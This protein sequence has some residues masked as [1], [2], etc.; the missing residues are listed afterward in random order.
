MAKLLENPSLQGAKGFLEKLTMTQKLIGGGLIGAIFI[1]LMF[2]ILSSTEQP[3]AV[4][5]SELE[6]SDSGK[7][8][9]T[10]SEQEIDY[11]LREGGAKILV[12]KDKV[13]LLRIELANQGLP[14]VS[15]VGYELFDR[16]NLGMSEFVQKLNFKRAL[17]GELQN[18]IE[19]MEEVRKAR[20]HIVIPEKALFKKDQ[21]EPTASITLNLKS[22]RS[23]SRINIEGLQNL[24][25]SSVEGMSPDKVKVMD[26]KARLL[27]QEAL[28][29]NSIAGKTALQHQQQQ[30]IESH[31]SSKVQAML[32]GVLGSGNAKVSVNADL[33]F[34]Q[35]EQEK[36][37]FDPEGQVVRSEQNIKDVSENADSLSYPY[38][39]QAKDETNQIANY[40]IS[41]NVEKIIH[42]VGAVQRLT[43]SVLINGKVAVSPGEDGQKTLAYTPRSDEEMKQFR[44]IVQNAIGYD[45]S[46]NDQI[47]VINVPFQHS[48]DKENYMEEFPPK[49]YEVPENKRI[50]LLVGL[51]FMIFIFMLLIL[52][53]KEVRTRMRIA[54][55]LPT[56]V[57]I[58]EYDIEEED[59]EEDM[60]ELELD[61]DD[62]LLLPAELPEQ[63]L[64]E[65]EAPVT[66][67][68]L[69]QEIESELELE[70]ESM[71]DYASADFDDEDLS[72]DALMKLEIK[73]K[74]EQFFEDNTIEAVKLL[75]IFMKEEN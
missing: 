23:L 47:S 40:E 24:I 73:G 38:V 9:E 49:W 44:E 70:K 6:S 69:D 61:D 20:V 27:S 63:L 22:G 54:M 29:E 57:V 52:Q 10:L 35:I 15:N 32:D 68:S 1:G 11:E 13:D 5:F 53:S 46:R 51:L 67:T 64:L 2:V 66:D 59:K 25:A 31:L 33:D 45:P 30:R 4:L 16:T 28:D 3:M 36:T 58:D 62:L 42:D 7:I 41:R 12:P 74:V 34:T 75:R 39:N 43:I 14:E 18:T 48:L 65:G 71:S 72:E 17:E 56:K 21:K 55:G 37:N 26:Q 8:I 50:L 19:A 60:E